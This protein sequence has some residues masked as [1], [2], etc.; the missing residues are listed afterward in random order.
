MTLTKQLLI[1][2]TA[3][4]LLACGS[5]QSENAPVSEQKAEQPNQ[6]VKEQAS[7]QSLAESYDAMVNTLFKYRAASATMFGL[8][9]SDIGFYADDQY[10]SYGVG[11][12][13]DLREELRRLSAKIAEYPETG[14]S[15]QELENKK[16]MAHIARFYAGN[17]LFPFGYID[18][19][20]G[21]SPFVINQINGPLIDFPRVMM[22]DQKITNEQEAL[23]YIARLAQFD[24][25]VDS[26]ENKFKADAEQ[27]W[28][29][30]KVV[31]N[32]ALNYFN[33]FLATEPDRHP[34]VIN[35]VEKLMKLDDLPLDKRN[36]LIEEAKRQ[37][38][39]V[40]YP[41]YRSV[42]ELTKNNLDRARDDHGIWSQP[43]G[44][45][46]YKDA[47]RQLGDS[48]L[49]ADEIH[50]KGLQE[51]ARISAEMDKI[52]RAQ[53]YSRGSVG[54]R[55]QA[56]NEESRF[57]YE[58][59]DTGR[60]KLLDDLNKHIAEINLKMPSLFK[61]KPPY[62]VEVRA[63]PKEIQDGAPG[64]QYTPPAIDGSKP[65]IY[66][67]NL[68]DMKANPSFGLKTLTY[69]EANPG[70]HWQIALNL[71]QDSL[72]TMRRLIAYNAYVEGWALYSELVASEMGMYQDDP[73]GDLGRLQAELFRA[74]RLVVDTG[75]HHKRWTREKAIEYMADTTGT[76]E[77]DVVA[78][79]ERYMTW[80]GQA[81]GYKMGMLNIVAQR[82]FAKKQLAEKFDLAEFHD[83]I[84]LGGAVPMTI[85]ND[86]VASW[87]KSKQ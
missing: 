82:E 22:T 81:L 35:F 18:T 51:V 23:A 7:K 86:K 44:V 40:V 19:W 26:V 69:H 75:L 39:E 76:A 80:P 50:T 4:F 42:T 27:G 58:D 63:F 78:E 3:S 38:S 37:V 34:L 28:I 87:V 52:L 16:V 74:V 24:V 66:W 1:A 6:P 41:A 65:G 12:E 11:T 5:E 43:N 2:F 25:F 46:Y 54:K 70:H 85:L 45:E 21:L 68:R 77:S 15:K 8:S 64:G 55:M 53:G 60:Q 56:L 17:E 30:P 73:F 71:A 31:L 47:I 20:M 67:I 14:L 57:L 62:E 79:I 29:A 72:P 10:E 83:L 33:R 9:Q 84:L 49:T 32:G 48:D 13:R 61:T 36:A 59:S